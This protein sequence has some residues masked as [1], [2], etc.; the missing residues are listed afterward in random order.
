MILLEYRIDSLHGYLTVDLKFNEDLSVILG[1]NGEGKTSALNLLSNLLQFNLSQVA[2]VNFTRIEV[3]YKEYNSDIVC[4]LEVTQRERSLKIKWTKEQLVKNATFG[5]VDISSFT[6]IGSNLISPEDI[7]SHLD[8]YDD[9]FFLSGSARQSSKSKRSLLEIQKAVV[10]QAQLTFVRLDRTITAL[11]SSGFVSREGFTDG[12]KTN[13]RQSSSKRAIRDPL[14]VV[15]DV[16]GKKY[17]Q[18][19]NN[20]E[21]TN[22]EAQQLSFDLH[23][24]IGTEKTASAKELKTLEESL[25][26]LENEW[27]QSTF[28][29]KERQ[30][31]FDSFIKRL[32]GLTSE[33]RTI[34]EGKRTGRRTAAE[35]AK[36]IIA[37]EYSRKVESLANLLQLQNSKSVNA[38]SELSTYLIEVNRF[39]KDSGKVLFLSSLDNSLRF[40]LVNENE[41]VSFTE[42]IKGNPISGLSSGERQILII[43]TYLAFSPSTKPRSIFLV[44]EPELSLHLRWQAKLIPAMLKLSPKGCQIVMATHAPEIAGRAREKCIPVNSKKINKIPQKTDLKNV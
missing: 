27:K 35:D 2:E 29:S 20:F 33:A 25:G 18:Y 37:S 13:V 16:V 43:L 36:L 24:E 11:D 10:E 38:F 23:F 39:L 15:Q 30:R 6:N 42:A 9:D 28:S 34:I 22:I 21:K 4:L 31:K 8:L 26:R 17:L 14:N 40:K 41:A 7:I 19:R 5:G 32:T 3:I 1:G 12:I 44:D